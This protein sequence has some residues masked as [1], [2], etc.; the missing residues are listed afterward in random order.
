[1]R[2]AQEEAGGRGCGRRHPVLGLGGRRADR[3]VHPAHLRSDGRPALARA[4]PPH[5]PGEA[6]C[7]AAARRLREGD[8][9]GH[10]RGGRRR[11]GRGRRR[12]EPGV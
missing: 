1:E 11:P 6:G 12:H 5:R 9:G 3:P 2:A 10:R 8:S 4:D 7:R